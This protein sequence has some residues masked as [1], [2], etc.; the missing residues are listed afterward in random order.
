MQEGK[1]ERPSGTL[2]ATACKEATSRRAASHPRGAPS[3]LQQRVSPISLP[4]HFFPSPV[5]TWLPPSS[6][7]TWPP[8]AHLALNEARATQL[9]AKRYFATV[10]AVLGTRPP[11]LPAAAHPCGWLPAGRSGHRSWASAGSAASEA[12]QRG[13]AAMPSVPARRQRRG[14][15]AVAVGVPPGVP[16]GRPEVG[17][18]SRGQGVQGAVRVRRR[19]GRPSRGPG[20]GEPKWGCRRRS[21]RRG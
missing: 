19:G 4:L 16:W 17:K 15:P 8:G 2:S 14:V 7:I 3:H 13:P 18:R 1:R 20:Q 9:Y 10:V 11:L 6:P 5:P 12:P 21:A